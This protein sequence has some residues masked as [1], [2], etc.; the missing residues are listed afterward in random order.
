[1]TP[2]KL[3]M[4]FEEAE[5]ERQECLR[6]QAEREAKQRLQDEK[7][8]FEEAKLEMVTDLIKY[9]IHLLAHHI[10]MSCSFLVRAE[11]QYFSARSTL[12]VN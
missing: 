4:T 3:K 11:I 2:G 1:M 5:K 10:S 6:K 7:K 9:L 8:A 12:E